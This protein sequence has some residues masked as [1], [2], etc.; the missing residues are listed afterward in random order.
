[1]AA[2]I[3]RSAS[4]RA[5]GGSSRGGEPYAVEGDDVGE[6]FASALLHAGHLAH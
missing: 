5:D 1:M 2:N 4:D 6:G 3:L